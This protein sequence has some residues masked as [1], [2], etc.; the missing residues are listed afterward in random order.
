MEWPADDMGINVKTSTCG[1]VR[2]DV[3]GSRVFWSDVLAQLSALH[4]DVIRFESH[5]LRQS[6]SN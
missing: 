5:V 6:S 4:S 3:R 2:V 1:Q